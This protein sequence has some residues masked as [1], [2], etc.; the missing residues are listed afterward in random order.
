MGNI[1]SI[2]NMRISKN[3]KACGTHIPVLLKVIPK[4]TGDVCEV[5]CGFNSTPLLHWLLQ[6]R[7]LVTYESDKGYYNFARQFRSNNHKIIKVDDWS[8]IDYDRHYGV[9]FIDHTVSRE[10]KQQGKQRGDDAIKFI[11]ADIIIMH[12][13]EPESVDNYRYNIVFPKFKYRC[14]WTNNKPNTSVVSNVIDV[15]KWLS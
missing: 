14:D 10:S 15:T 13:T 7:K 4:T 9:V 12:D 2:P 6:G 11:N 8:K 5:G 1:S 3:Y